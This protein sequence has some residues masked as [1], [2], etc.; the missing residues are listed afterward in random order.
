MADNLKATFSKLEFI[1]LFF[2]PFSES[3]LSFEHLE[4]KTSLIAEVFLQLLTE[5]KVLT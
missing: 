3:V 4:T 1:C 5:K 2:L